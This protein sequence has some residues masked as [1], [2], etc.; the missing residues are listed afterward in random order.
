MWQTGKDVSDCGFP[1]K[2]SIIDDQIAEMASLNFTAL[3]LSL[4][5][6]KKQRSKKIETLTQTKFR[7]I[8]AL[9]SASNL[10]ARAE[11]IKKNLCSSSLTRSRFTLSRA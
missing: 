7:M 2:K 3:E 8:H 10:R 5:S 4:F 6:R 11:K 9:C 1:F